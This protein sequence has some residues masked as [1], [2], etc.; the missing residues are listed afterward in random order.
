MAIPREV[1]TFQE[2]RSQ[3]SHILKQ[4]HIDPKAKSKPPYSWNNF[5]NVITLDSSGGKVI[6]CNITRQCLASLTPWGF[7]TIQIEELTDKKFCLCFAQIYKLQ[8]CQDIKAQ[9]VKK[10]CT[11]YILNSGE[12]KVKNSRITFYKKS[13]IEDIIEE[14]IKKGTITDEENI[15]RFNEVKKSTQVSNPSKA[16]T[17]VTNNVR[18]TIINI[19]D[20]PTQAVRAIINAKGEI[21]PLGDPVIKIP[22]VP[23]PERLPPSNLNIHDDKKFMRMLAEEQWSFVFALHRKKETAPPKRKYSEQLNKTQ[24]DPNKRLR[25]LSF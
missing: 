7:K 17:D 9:F 6:L 2:F 20:K 18:Q 8:D 14:E 5:D 4:I 19:T 21:L 25:S 11:L 1:I 22:A 15:R 10:L 13:E 3:Y 12:I 16:R 23:N 24:S